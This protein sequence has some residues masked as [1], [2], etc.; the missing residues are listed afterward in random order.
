[1]AVGQA[2]AVAGVAAYG[3]ARPTGEVEARD[4]FQEMREHVVKLQQYATANDKDLKALHTALTV[5]VSNASG[6][7]RAEV[8]SI[9]MYVTGYLL[10]LSR[11]GGRRPTKRS[12][13]SDTA[14][15]DALQSL[16]KTSGKPS[17]GGRGAGGVGIQGFGSRPSSMPVLM[18][19][20]AKRPRLRTP[21]KDLQQAAQQ[22]K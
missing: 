6:E 11:V 22:R 17:N 9:R 16:L 10:A 13:A 21:A 7:C 5:G 2:V 15:A 4:G 8:Q 1:M 3:A 12:R 20:R 18:P 19:R 14:V